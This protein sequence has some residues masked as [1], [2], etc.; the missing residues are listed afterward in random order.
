MT[1]A[2]HDNQAQDNIRNTGV[3]P[4]RFRTNYCCKRY[5]LISVKEEEGKSFAIWGKN[6]GRK[7]NVKIKRIAFLT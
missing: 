1:P 4:C 3:V 2:V 5:S 7:W 6:Q